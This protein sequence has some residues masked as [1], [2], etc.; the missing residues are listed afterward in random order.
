MYLVNCTSFLRL[1]LVACL[2]TI[3]LDLSIVAANFTSPVASPNALRLPEGAGAKDQYI[4]YPGTSKQSR[5]YKL[6]LQ[7]LV[8]SDNVKE[9]ATL[10]TGVLF[11]LADLDAAEVENFSSWNPS[12]NKVSFNNVEVSMNDSQLEER[13]IPF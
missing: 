9:Y 3:A 10:F 2:V 11:W 13:Y 8:G 6:D 1:G 7:T 5:K 4:I 12:V